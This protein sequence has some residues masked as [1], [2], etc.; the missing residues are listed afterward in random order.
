MSTI[1]T[2]KNIITEDLNALLKDL[3]E[4]DLNSM[5]DLTAMEKKARNVLLLLSNRKQTLL[6]TINEVEELDKIMKGREHRHTSR[7]LTSINNLANV[8][9]NK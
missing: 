1:E 9:E 3:D 8:Q 2:V 5:E 6:I 4:S 7:D